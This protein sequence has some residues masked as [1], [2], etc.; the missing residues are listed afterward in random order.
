MTFQSR[1]FR[2]TGRLHLPEAPSPAVIIGSHG[3]FGTAASAKQVALASACTAAGLGY[4]RF[5]HRGCGH[6]Q[7]DFEQV[8]TLQGRVE[9]IHAAIKLIT[10]RTDTGSAF[11]LFG[12]SLGGAACIRAAGTRHPAAMVLCAA[13]VRSRQVNPHGAGRGNFPSNTVPP[14]PSRLHFDVAADLSRIRDVLL[15]HGDADE[16]VPH[17][18]AVEIFATASDPKKLIM[19]PGGDHRMTEASHQNRFIQ[20]TVAWF[21]D[22]LLASNSSKS[23]Q[24]RL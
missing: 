22:R 7:G 17:R 1:E 13:P 11:G 3:L 12:S 4:L 2:L 21:K 10:D 5:D 8:T 16:V 15:F 14:H 19:L 20:E 24:K 9:D 18:H 23:Y 6:S